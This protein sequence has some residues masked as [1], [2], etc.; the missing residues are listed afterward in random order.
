MFRQVSLY[1]L[2]LVSLCLVLIVGIIG[3]GGGEDPEDDNN[4]PSI[5]TITDRNLD[6]G[7]E[8][9]VRVYVTDMDL[10]DTHIITASSGNTSV[11]AVS[12]DDT[13]LTITGIGVGI[14][15]ITVSA[16]DDSGQD[17]AEA[18]PVTFHV[19]LNEP[20]PPPVDKGPCIVGMT[21]QPGE[22]CTYIANQKP[23]FF[24][25]G[26]DGGGCRSS[27]QTGY[28]EIFGLPVEIEPLD[29]D[30]YFCVYDD[31]RNDTLYNTNFSADKKPDG[32]WT[33]EN[34]P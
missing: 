6:V 2:P 24:F 20:P 1:S 16:T 29:D 21:L 34:V 10:D 15:I 31:I 30:S 12:V 32:S 3:C 17:N 14:T 19:T 8:I 13:S 26:E 33:I 4:Q 22:G 11:A 23:V 27:Q 5:E 7:D 28:A 18:I 9:S 25:V